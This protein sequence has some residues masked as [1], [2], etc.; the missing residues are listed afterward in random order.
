M[1][2][3]LLADSRLADYHAVNDQVMQ[4]PRYIAAR[5][6]VAGRIRA[7]ERSIIDDSK[8]SDDEYHRLTSDY[9]YELTKQLL[10]ETFYLFEEARAARTPNEGA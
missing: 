3:S 5:A 8:V 1:P 7:Y 9:S 6:E 10:R 2:E 4:D